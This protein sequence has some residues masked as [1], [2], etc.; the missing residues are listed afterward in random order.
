MACL[1]AE[2]EWLLLVFVTRPPSITS[3]SGPLSHNL[4]KRNNNCDIILLAAAVNHIKLV[5]RRP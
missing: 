4:H 3:S 2:I 5:R 1:H